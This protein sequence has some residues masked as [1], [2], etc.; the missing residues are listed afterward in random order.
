M[1]S[2]FA[3]P[4]RHLAEP[5]ADAVTPTLATVKLLLDR[6]GAA[7]TLSISV[8]MLDLL[9]RRG[10]IHPT[11]IGRLPRFTIAELERFISQRGE[12]RE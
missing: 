2:D 12:G 8:S 9:V 6:R 4:T 10:E 5:P 1:P 7:R 11:Y 3:F